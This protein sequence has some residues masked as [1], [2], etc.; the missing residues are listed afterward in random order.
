MYKPERRT[1]AVNNL[2]GRLDN[3]IAETLDAI[4]RDGAVSDAGAPHP[5]L[6]DLAAL[7]S[8]GT[9]LRDAQLQRWAMNSVLAERR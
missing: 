1:F 7:V 4:E 3:I 5:A 2:R 9:G 6:S 8:A